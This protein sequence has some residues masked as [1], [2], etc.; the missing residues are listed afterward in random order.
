MN[1]DTRELDF[2]SRRA[3]LERLLRKQEMINSMRISQATKEDF[4]REFHNLEWEIRLLEKE[5]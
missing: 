5:E 4:A 1:L 2:W 3:R